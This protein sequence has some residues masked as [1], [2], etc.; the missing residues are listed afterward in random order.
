MF[1]NL[2]IHI[3]RGLLKFLSIFND[4]IKKGVDGRKETFEI[5]NSK[6]D[7]YE[8]KVWFHCASL[9]E[10]EQGMPVFESIRKEYP[11]FQ[12]ILSF[13]SPSGYEIRKDTPIAD[14]VVYLPLDTP[15]NARRW[16]S[17]INPKL[18]IF[19]KY[20]IW[21]NY[22]LE[23]K[24]R[25][26]P[27]VLIS[28]R[29]REE[30]MYFQWFGGK[31][32]KGLKSFE[33]IFLQDMES[34]VLLKKVGYK[35]TIVSGDTRFDRVYNRLSSSTSLP[36]LENFKEEKR[37]VVFGSTWPEDENLIFQ[38]ISDLHD[39]PIK[40]LIAPHEI[41]EKHISN[42]L[43]GL[44]FPTLLY[45]DIKDEENDKFPSKILILDTIGQLA[46]TYSYADIAYVG[47]AVGKTGLHNILEPA[48]FGL[49]ILIGPNHSK[50]PE[51]L[52]LVSKGGVL[53]FQNYSELKER[54]TSLMDNMAYRKQI[55]EI[56]KK[57]VDNS[58]GAVIQILDHIRIYF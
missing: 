32:K 56:N 40:F 44:R 46:K 20:D 33:H 25:K 19:V 17:T 53:S 55:G 13:F 8:E 18:T 50:F 12:I 36:W 14:I 26:L 21:P 29:F 16:V 3:L 58:K 49:P 34:E 38:L 10:F 28:A 27:S 48:V 51:A 57:F 11:Q 23:L 1:Y 24:R 31:L 2:G 5:L 30:Q 22:L 7:P 41:D 6:I 9:G 54:I 42:V 4:K 45:S 35:N 39:K 43:A 15:K 37:L 52:T 47:G